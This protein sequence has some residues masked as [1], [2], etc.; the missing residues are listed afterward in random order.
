M[1]WRH[2]ICQKGGQVACPLRNKCRDRGAQ[3]PYVTLHSS[4]Y[5]TDNKPYGCIRSSAERRDGES[6]DMCQLWT[7]A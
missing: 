7:H 2:I 5:I 4:A 1:S 3:S 6:Q